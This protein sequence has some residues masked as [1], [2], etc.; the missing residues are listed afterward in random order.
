MAATSEQTQGQE[1]YRRLTA[2]TAWARIQSIDNGIATTW[3]RLNRHNR[4]AQEAITSLN[5]Q[6]DELMQIIVDEA[7][8]S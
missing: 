2:K 8:A 3:E 1:R 4:E 7:V 5:K 6:R